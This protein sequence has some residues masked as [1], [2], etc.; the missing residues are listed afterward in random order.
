MNQSK[1]DIVYRG[2]SGHHN[3]NPLWKSNKKNGT[4]RMYFSSKFNFTIL[5]WFLLLLPPLA[6][7][8]FLNSYCSTEEF[9]L[10][11]S[12]F[13]KWSRS[14]FF[15]F[16]SGTHSRLLNKFASTRK[17]KRDNVRVCVCV[18]ERGGVIEER[19]EM[20]DCVRVF[21]ERERKKNN[22]NRVLCVQKHR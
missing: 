8:F 7:L 1:Y 2:I 9:L 11:A 10:W 15:C 12:T 3:E 5:I 21:R 14:G 4:E 13:L 17:R 19:E 22:E 16:V 6:M 20:C 18:W